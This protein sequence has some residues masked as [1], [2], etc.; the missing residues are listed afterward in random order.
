ME[1]NADFQALELGEKIQQIEV[2]GTSFGTD[3]VL[4]FH[5][6]NIHS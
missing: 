2:D 1:L 4:R 3:K 5:A 6:Y